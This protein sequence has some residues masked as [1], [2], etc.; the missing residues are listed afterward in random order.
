MRVLPCR[1]NRTRTTMRVRISKPRDKHSCTSRTERIA[2]IIWQMNLFVDQHW[3]HATSTGTDSCVWMDVG[4]MDL[5]TVSLPGLAAEVSSDKTARLKLT[6]HNGDLS[7]E[8]IC[9]RHSHRMT[10]RKKRASRLLFSSTGK[11]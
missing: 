2:C 6:H 10:A 11:D 8:R 4:W 5:R 1:K 7:I 9:V 3:K